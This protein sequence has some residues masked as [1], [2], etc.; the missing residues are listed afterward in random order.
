[1]R[2]NQEAS[3]IGSFSYKGISFS[4]QLVDCLLETFDVRFLAQSSVLGMLSV[5]FSNFA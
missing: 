3:S 1:M 5:A 2:L 4:A